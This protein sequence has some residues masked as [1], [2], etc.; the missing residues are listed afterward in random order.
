MKIYPNGLIFWATP[1]GRNQPYTVNVTATSLTG[2]FSNSW[3]VTVAP[4]YTPIITRIEN[5]ADSNMKIIEGIV[6]Y[7]GKVSLEFSNDN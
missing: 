4:T 1:I 6:S 7:S 3:N 5:F 2:G